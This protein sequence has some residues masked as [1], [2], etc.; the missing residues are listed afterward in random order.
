MSNFKGYLFQSIGTDSE[1]NTKYT[2]FP[3]KY[4]K[5][6]SW[7]STPDQREELVAYRDDNSRDLTR[8]TASGKKSIFS[9]TTRDGIHLADKIAIQKFFTSAETDTEQRK[10]QLQFWNEETNDYDTGYFYRPNMAFPIK[11]ITDDDIIY[12]EM[13]IDFIE[14]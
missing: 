12:G 2:P 8:V 11:K 3:N 6:E 4:I 10:I 13:T 5:Y 7:S 9:F 14:Y 1:G